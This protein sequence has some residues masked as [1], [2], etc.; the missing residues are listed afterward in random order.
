MKRRRAKRY[1]NVTAYLDRHGIERWR[2]RKTG[3]AA[4]NFK[5]RYGSPEFEE[6]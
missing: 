6:E 5:A 2:W 4:H 1:E 3:F